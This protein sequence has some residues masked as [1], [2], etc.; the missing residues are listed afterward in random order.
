MS[1]LKKLVNAGNA[2]LL[3]I[4]MIFIFLMM[5]VTVAD[6][7]GRYFFN[8]PIPG[9]FEL[10]RFSLGAIV[11]TAL[12][13]SQINKVHIA[14]RILVSKFPP[15]WQNFIEIFNYLVAFVIFMLACWQMF[16][17]T[18]R[19]YASAQVTSVLGVPIYPFVLLSAVG[20][21]FFTLVLLLD[22]VK[23]INKLFSRG[24]ED[25]YSSHWSS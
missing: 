1:F 5:F 19:L 18:Q 4:S 6:V 2:P 11:C 14:I 7:G 20:V 15:I 12:G 3:K 13:Y 10:T 17:Y 22:L 24:V 16:V 25:E 8:S 9:V 23:A 21:V